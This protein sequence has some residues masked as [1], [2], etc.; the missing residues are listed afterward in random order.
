MIQEELTD[1]SHSIRPPLQSQT[2]LLSYY[3]RDIKDKIIGSSTMTEAQRI[4][5]EQCLLF[6]G[7]CSSEVLHR[8]MTQYVHDIIKLNWPQRDV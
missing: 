1:E 3:C 7:S 8:A 6:Q 5:D 4:A 2:E